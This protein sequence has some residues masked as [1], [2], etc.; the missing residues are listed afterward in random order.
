MVLLGLVQ[1]TNYGRWCRW[2]L[3][4]NRRSGVAWCS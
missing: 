3:Q 1:P 4:S 2:W